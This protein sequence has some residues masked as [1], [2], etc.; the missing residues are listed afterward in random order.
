MA[1][2]VC[3]DYGIKRCGIAA[4]DPF[5]IIVSAV[6]TIETA[7]LMDFLDNYLANESVEK[8]VVGLPVHK[9]GNFTGLKTNIDDFVQKFKT[10]FAHIPVD[11]ADEQFSSVHAKKIIL[12]IGIKKEK[13]KDK[14]LIDKISAVI[15]LQRY[16]KH[17]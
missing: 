8:L 1:R 11:F 6:D 17:I 2:I 5:Q 14:A 4:T 9:D 13:R 10:K 16:L 3:I 15:I 7:K 12:D